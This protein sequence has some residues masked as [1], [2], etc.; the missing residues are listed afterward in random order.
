MLTKS[1]HTEKYPVLFTFGLQT[2]SFQKVRSG[3]TII[4]QVL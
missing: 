3:I 1:I 4:E 2:E